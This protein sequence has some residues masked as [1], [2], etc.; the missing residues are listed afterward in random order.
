MNKTFFAFM[1]NEW[2]MRQFRFCQDIEYPW[3]CQMAKNINKKCI[4]AFLENIKR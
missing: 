2:D 1:R 3:I 4:D